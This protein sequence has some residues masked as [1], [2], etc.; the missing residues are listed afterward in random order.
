M[1]DQYVRA[2]D[3]PYPG[4]YLVTVELPPE[5]DPDVWMALMTAYRQIARE[6]VKGDIFVHGTRVMKGMGKHASDE[7]LRLDDQ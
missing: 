7:Y 4:S 5:T 3:G 6:M 1:S 2:H